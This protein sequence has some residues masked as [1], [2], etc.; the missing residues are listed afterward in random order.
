MMILL[1]L[2]RVRYISQTHIHKQQASSAG[3]PGS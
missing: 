1:L 3:D 2:C